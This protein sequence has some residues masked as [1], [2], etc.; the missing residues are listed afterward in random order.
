MFLAQENTMWVEEKGQQ[1][2]FCNV[3]GGFICGWLFQNLVQW[4]L[5]S[6]KNLLTGIPVQYC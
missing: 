1:C 2:E 3:F 5:H 6:W 4:L